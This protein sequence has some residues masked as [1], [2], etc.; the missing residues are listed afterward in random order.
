[1][2]RA[3]GHDVG[4]KL[5]P[6]FVEDTAAK[7]GLS[8]RTIDRDINRAQHI[9]PEVREEIRAM[10]EI[11]DS[12][13]ELDALAKASPA[14]QAEAVKA[15]KTGKAKNVRSAMPRMPGQSTIKAASKPKPSGLG[16]PREKWIEATSEAYKAPSSELYEH[17]VTTRQL[18]ADAKHLGEISPEK[19]K[20][21]AQAFTDVL[22]TGSGRL[23]I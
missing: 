14:Q 13:V 19:R 9:V 23:R 22:L 12:G 11:A 10:P 5:T 4:A 8:E 18:I 21:L 2:N 15:V 1:M 16:S 6:T 3:L 7:T 17:L 20:Q